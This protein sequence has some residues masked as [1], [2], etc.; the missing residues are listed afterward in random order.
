MKKDIHME[1]AYQVITDY[2]TEKDC[3]CQEFFI[4]GVVSP[5]WSKKVRENRNERIRQ[6]KEWMDM[7][8][9]KKHSSKMSNDHSY[10]LKK[11]NGKFKIVFAKTNVE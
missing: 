7:P 11:E 5:L 4:E 10:K 9:N 8:D 6:L 1:M 3:K 2:A